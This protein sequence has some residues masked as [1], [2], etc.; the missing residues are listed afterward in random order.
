MCYSFIPRKFAAQP[1]SKETT[2][3]VETRQV[4]PTEKTGAVSDEQ[5]ARQSYAKFMEEMKR[6]ME[7]RQDETVR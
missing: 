7:Q 2:A 5:A 1:D 6:L 3:P 4:M